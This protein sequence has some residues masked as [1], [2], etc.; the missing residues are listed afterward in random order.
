MSGSRIS[1]KAAKGALP[2]LFAVVAA[3]LC[4][5]SPFDP[6]A[7]SAAAD[8]ASTLSAA[9]DS[10]AAGTEEGNGAE[11]SG[12]LISVGFSQLGSESVWRTANTESVQN[13]LTSENGFFLLYDNA[14]Q[15]QQNQIKAL[16]SFISQQVDVMVF[17]P[18]QET[19]WD[20]VLQEAKDAD[21]PVILLDRTINVKDDSLY[22]TFVGENMLEQGT[23]AGR[24][25]EQYLSG[26]GTAEEEQNIVVLRGTAGSSAEL[27]RSVGFNNIALQH[28]SWHLEAEVEG[29]FTQ[30]KGREVMEQLLNEYDDID[31]VVAQNDDMAIGA[32]EAIE[33]AG[34]TLGE[35]GDMIMISFDGTKRALELVQQGIISVDVECNPLSGPLLSEV[36]R[37]IVDGEDVEKEYYMEEQVFTKDNVD[38]YINDRAY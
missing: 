27:G 16:R 38:E 31:V 30:A 12:N 23:R 20:T 4:A 26:K 28:K 35:D 29:E 22:T 7:D 25:L 10:T 6:F 32:V 3:V 21:I 34:K 1:A 5:C 37:K 36:I 14:R 17:C 33:A 19:G 8:N 18:V 13:T 24:W 2:L 9:A 11:A 15:D